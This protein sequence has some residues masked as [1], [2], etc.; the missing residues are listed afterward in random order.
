[1]TNEA[2]RNEDAVEPLVRLAS[3]VRELLAVIDAHDM[4][5]LDCDRSGRRCCDCLTLARKKVEACM[6]ND[7]LSG[8]EA[9]RSDAML[10]AAFD[11]VSAARRVR[12]KFG[13]DDNGNPLDWTEWR[14]VDDAC[15]AI[16][17]IAAN[18]RI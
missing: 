7:K 1:M 12:A 11:L 5:T 16:D 13:T 8:G 2:K 3:A 14:D 10:A 18:N 17:S 6:P 9:V 4:D 15:N